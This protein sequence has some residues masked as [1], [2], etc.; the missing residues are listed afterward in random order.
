MEINENYKMKRPTSHKQLLIFPNNSEYIMDNP[1]EFLKEPQRREKFS[2]KELHE[3]WKR[4]VNVNFKNIDKKF[5]TKKSQTMRRI[6]TEQD[7]IQDKQFFEIMHGIYYDKSGKRET[8]KIKLK[9]NIYDKYNDKNSYYLSTQNPWNN[10]S[11][12]DLKD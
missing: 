9:K 2:I 12:F 4:K 3:K 6:K 7:E 1:K 11:V 10:D 8:D 5:D